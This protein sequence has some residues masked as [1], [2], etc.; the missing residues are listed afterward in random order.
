MIVKKWEKI[1]YGLHVYSYTPL[2]YNII[3]I[4]TT[5]FIQGLYRSALG[6]SQQI[7]IEYRTIKIKENDKQLIKFKSYFKKISLKLRFKSINS[8]TGFNVYGKIVPKF[9][10]RNSESSGTIGLEIVLKPVQAQGRRLTERSSWEVASNQ[11]FN[12]DR[13]LFI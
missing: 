6:A 11:V 12:I 3:I 1:K 10:S 13:R 7:L 9:W 2:Q 8:V 4:I 5:I